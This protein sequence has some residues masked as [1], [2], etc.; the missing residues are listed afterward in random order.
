MNGRQAGNLIGF[1][2]SVLIALALSG[3]IFKA[4][5]VSGVIKVATRRLEQSAVKTEP[6]KPQ[7]AKP[8]HDPY[9]I[10]EPPPDGYRIRSIPRD[11]KLRAA[12]PNYYPYMEERWSAVMQSK[13]GNPTTACPET[14]FQIAGE[15]HFTTRYQNSRHPDVGSLFKNWGNQHRERATDIILTRDGQGQIWVVDVARDCGGASEP[16]WQVHGIIDDVG[17]WRDPFPVAQEPQPCPPGWIRQPDGSCKSPDE[18]EPDQGVIGV[19]EEIKEIEIQQLEE[20]RGIRSALQS[21]RQQP[22]PARKR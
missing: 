4:G 2:G 10:T 19:L 13:S 14:V 17:R 21:L 15:L 7:P 20:L 8:K 11:S 22:A 6:F 18:P 9:A 1:A 12:A 16:A 3:V 5:E